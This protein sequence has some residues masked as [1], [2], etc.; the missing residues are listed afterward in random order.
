MKKELCSRNR[1]KC[2]NGETNQDPLVIDA[3]NEN[4]LTAEKFNDK[5]I[6]AAVELWCSDNAEATAKYGHIKD[7]DVSGVTDMNCLF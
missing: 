4:P 5:T 2:D 7:W 3:E 1:Q 6:V